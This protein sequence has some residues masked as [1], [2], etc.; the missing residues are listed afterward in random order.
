VPPPGGVRARGWTRRPRWLVAVAGVLLLL[1]VAVGGLL[2]ATRGDDSRTPASATHSDATTTA[3]SGG[4]STSPSE[5][6]S[7]GPT[8]YGVRT[9]V[10]T[11]LTTAA[12]DPTKSY[13]M[14]TTDFQ[15]AS[16]GLSGYRGFWGHVVRIDRI[17]TISPEVGDPLGVS[18]RYTYTTDDG[19]A[20]TENVH[21]RLVYDDG[22]Y[23][24]AGE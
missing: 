19:R 1:V 11:Y 3:G 16:G 21:L 24:I 12:S 20:H 7:A 2:L 9:F 22:R 4:G 18:Y 14:L 15:A 10:S 23:L 8:D 6:P 5:T 13:T 17:A